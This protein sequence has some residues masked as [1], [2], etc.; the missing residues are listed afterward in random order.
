M[1]FFFADYEWT[2]E[3]RDCMNEMKYNF[4]GRLPETSICGIR[5]KQNKY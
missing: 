1:Y 2:D 4:V 3:R 5:E